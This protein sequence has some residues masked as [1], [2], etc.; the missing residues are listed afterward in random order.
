M[1][2]RE[3]GPKGIIENLVSWNINC[4]I[5]STILFLDFIQLLAEEPTFYI[6]VQNFDMLCLCYFL[7]IL[8]KYLLK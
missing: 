4:H 3:R 8:E 1:L 2:K 7:S 5:A 6:E